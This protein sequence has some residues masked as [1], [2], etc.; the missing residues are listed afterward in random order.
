[1]IIL[2]ILTAGNSRWARKAKYVHGH[3]SWA[4]YRE[5][6]KEGR[7]HYS[8]TI[9]RDP[10]DRLVS[11]YL[12]MRS[13]PRGRLP[14]YDLVSKLTPREFLLERLEPVRFYI[15][16]FTVRQ[17]QGTLFDYPSTAQQASA[18]VERAKLN[19]SHLSYVGQMD[20]FDR[21]F[22]NIVQAI[23]YPYSEAAVPRTNET[24][25]SDADTKELEDIKEEIIE[26][27][28]YEA[29]DLVR[30]D[31]ELFD[32]FKFSRQAKRFDGAAAPI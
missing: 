20:T 18:M 28:A 15:D 24:V 10:V 3:F 2:T 25:P 9:L 11:L 7:P 17:F 27:L 1:M 21:D 31:N 13:K 32:H 14:I 30:L 5:I 29:Q 19:L 8:F 22:N 12:F 4:T 23:S 16:N 6:L 26:I